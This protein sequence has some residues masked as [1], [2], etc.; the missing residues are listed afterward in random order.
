MTNIEN[1]NPEDFCPECGCNI[2]EARREEIKNEIFEKLHG[3]EL[4]S[5]RKRFKLISGTVVALLFAVIWLLFAKGGPALPAF[6]AFIPLVGFALFGFIFGFA[7]PQE[8]YRSK[9][10]RELWQNFSNE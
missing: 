3:S 7:V 2:A 5:I 8:F 10:E 4:K 1:E 6:R 9:K